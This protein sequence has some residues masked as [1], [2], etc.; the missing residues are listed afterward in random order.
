MVKMENILC[1]E[2]TEL[3]TSFYTHIQVSYDMSV[4][5]KSTDLV[6][7]TIKKIVPLSINLIGVNKGKD[8]EHGPIQSEV[9]MWLTRGAGGKGGLPD[10]TIQNHLLGPSWLEN[11]S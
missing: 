2:S 8:V 5:L 3:N 9:A 7:F 4:S 1:N 10:F 6:I 11:I